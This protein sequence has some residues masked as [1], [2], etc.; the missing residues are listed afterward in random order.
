V[1]RL[2]EDLRG[3]LSASRLPPNVFN[4]QGIAVGFHADDFHVVTRARLCAEEYPHDHVPRE[5]H[6]RE[7][8]GGRV[9]VPHGLPL[10]R[11][12]SHDLTRRFLRAHLTPGDRR[13]WNLRCAEHGHRS[14]DGSDRRSPMHYYFTLN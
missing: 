13:E 9:I 10:R 1:K 5:I 12:A 11:R 7:F 6:N 8:L 4:H 14:N 3:H 2:R